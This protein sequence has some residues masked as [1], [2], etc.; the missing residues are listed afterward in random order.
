MKKIEMNKKL[1]DIKT[2]YFI[3]IGGI[4]MSAIAR[5]FKSRGVQVSGYDKTVTVLTRELEAAGIPVHYM[6]MYL[7]FLSI[8]IVWYILRQFRQ[9]IRS[10]C[11]IKPM[12][13]MW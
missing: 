6:K 4:G 8:R 12:D 13:L 1:K 5:F 7:R 3:G 2:V 10:C 9:R 11:I